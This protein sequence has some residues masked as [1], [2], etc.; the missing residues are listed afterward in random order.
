MRYLALFLLP[1]MLLTTQACE[2]KIEKPE[3]TAVKFLTE[4]YIKRSAQGAIKLTHGNLKR[5]MEK[6]Y[7]INS[8]QRNV[9]RVQM[10]T[11]EKIRIVNVDMDFFRLNRHD[12]K[13]SYQLIGTRNDKRFIDVVMM[14]MAYI[15]DEW[16]IIDILPDRFAR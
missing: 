16:K 11:V 15:E 2:E 5:R 3:I 10:D 13:A 4:V 1:L 9:L 7:A 14:E 8:M 6:N 12:V